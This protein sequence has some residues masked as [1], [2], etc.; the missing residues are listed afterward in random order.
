MPDHQPPPELPEP[1][2]TRNTPPT[3][4]HS[5][6]LTPAFGG[7]ASTTRALKTSLQPKRV[8]AKHPDSNAKS[9]VLFQT[10]F[11]ILNPYASRSF[12]SRVS[13]S[14][15]YGA[16]KSH[17]WDHHSQSQALVQPWPLFAVGAPQAPHKSGRAEQPPFSPKLQTSLPNLIMTSGGCRGREVSPPGGAKGKLTQSWPCRMDPHPS[18]STRLAPVQPLTEVSKQS[19]RPNLY[20]SPTL[21]K[22]WKDLGKQSP[23]ID[24]PTLSPILTRGRN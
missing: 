5:G 3:Q 7:S 1:A 17:F 20:L 9:E 18:C 13:G 8:K 10:K 21:R 14:S 15:V 2:A 22:A 12:R 24:A 11:W 23:G 4:T 19:P 16:R 6:P